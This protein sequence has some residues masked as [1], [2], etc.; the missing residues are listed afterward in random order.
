MKGKAIRKST[1]SS[2]CSAALPTSRSLRHDEPPPAGPQIGLR[3]HPIHHLTLH[4]GIGPA[5][6][7]LV[8][9]APARPVGC[10]S[11]VR[12]SSL[13]SPRSPRTDP[14]APLA[15]PHLRRRLK[16]NYAAGH[17]HTASPS[18]H[19]PLNLA[20]DKSTQI[21]KMPK[22]SRNNGLTH[23]V[24]NRNGLVWR[25]DKGGGGG[26]KQPLSAFY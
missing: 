26:A 1:N 21:D 16:R 22:F 12:K 18:I 4:L 25:H 8:G 5:T 9:A 14:L 20:N 13:P 6:S 3:S 23:S 15:S 24:V 10:G 19:S 17:P 7:A 11:V 2:G